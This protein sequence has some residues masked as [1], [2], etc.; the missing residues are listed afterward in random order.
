MDILRSTIQNGDGDD[1]DDDDIR[2]KGLP[3]LQHQLVHD[4]FLECMSYFAEQVVHLMVSPLWTEQSRE[5]VICTH[6]SDKGS[7]GVWLIE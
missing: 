5:R 6:S 7:L 2:A 4:I 3:L 1:D